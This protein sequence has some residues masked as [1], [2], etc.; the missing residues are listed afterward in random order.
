[1]NKNG[2]EILFEREEFEWWRIKLLIFLNLI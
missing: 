1:L 2:F